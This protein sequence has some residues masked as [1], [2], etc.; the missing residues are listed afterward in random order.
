MNIVILGAG[1]VGSHIAAQLTGEGHDVVIIEKNPETAKHVANHVD[2][3][4]INDEGNNSAT[5]KRAGIEN[6][7]FFLSVVDSDEVNM[8]ESS[9]S[10]NP[11]GSGFEIPVFGCKRC[12]AEG[13]RLLKEALA[14]KN[15]MTVQFTDR[16]NK[17]YERHG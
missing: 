4:V 2:C 6:A 11:P 16:M 3:I 8:I 10:V 17:I 15:F 9:S 13:Y 12:Q 5:L 7:D 14:S 1:V